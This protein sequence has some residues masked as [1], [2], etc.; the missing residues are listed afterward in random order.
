M[1]LSFISVTPKAEENFVY[2]ARV[3]SQREDK[4]SKPEGLLNYL[5]KH[6]HWSPF[7][8]SHLSVEIETSKAIGIQLI[9]HRSFTFQEFSQRYQNV[10][11]L[12]DMFEEIEFRKQCE[13]NRQSSTEI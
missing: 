13:D 3:S 10:S 2:I 11:L 12:G 6:K 9:R 4:K 7:E 8:H 1:K 5:I